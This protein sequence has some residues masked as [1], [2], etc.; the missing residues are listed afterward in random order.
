M[1]NTLAKL[2]SIIFYG[3]GTAILVIIIGIPYL[4]FWGKVPDG[5]QLWL[6]PRELLFIFLCLALLLYECIKRFKK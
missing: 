6:G 2:L 5:L 3:L 1:K 4:I